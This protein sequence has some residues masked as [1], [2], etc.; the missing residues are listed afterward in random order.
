MIIKGKGNYRRKSVT[1]R[2]SVLSTKIDS[3]YLGY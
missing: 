2:Y 3:W 1:I